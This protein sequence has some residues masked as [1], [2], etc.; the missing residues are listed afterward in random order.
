MKAESL[1]L[2]MRHRNLIKAERQKDGKSF[3]LFRVNSELLVPRIEKLIKLNVFNSV[4]RVFGCAET[5]YAELSTPEEEIT[6][7]C[8]LEADIEI[9]E[10]QIAALLSK[11]ITCKN[12]ILAE[13]L[14]EI[15]LKS[16]LIFLDQKGK[17]QITAIDAKR[18]ENI[19]SDVI[20][21]FRSL[22]QKR[23]T[24]SVKEDC[25]LSKTLLDLITLIDKL[26]KLSHTGSLSSLHPKH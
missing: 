8:L 24:A 3:I 25:I 20:S 4:K 18:E 23:T 2:T 22:L 7:S 6:L 9:N 1:D 5:T 26:S 14:S 12:N 11:I 21:I 10:A 16:E 13:D 19:F 17:I 15:H